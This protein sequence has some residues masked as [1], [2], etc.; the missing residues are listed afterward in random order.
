MC[1]NVW[2][3][4]KNFRW[5]GMTS[6]QWT[7]IM[8]IVSSEFSLPKESGKKIYP[9]RTWK[10]W[11]SITISFINGYEKPQTQ[12]LSY[13]Q[14][15][16]MEWC[17]CQMLSTSA[18]IWYNSSGA[19]THHQN[20]SDHLSF[21]ICVWIISSTLR[22][23]RWRAWSLPNGNLHIVSL[24]SKGCWM[25]NLSTLN[26]KTLKYYDIFWMSWM[27]LILWFNPLTTSDGGYDLFPMHTYTLR[28]WVT[29]MG[30]LWNNVAVK[31]F[32][33]RHHLL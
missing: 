32:P 19:Y 13:P 17:C 33:V 8:H 22:N 21:N 20:L 9:Y 18:I 14:G 30:F 2:F 7:D 31:C 6:S 26:L 15:I 16:S 27:C 10:H 4:P 29:L 12:K 3:N 24:L 1:L 25:K 5:R 28:K 11:N 23:F